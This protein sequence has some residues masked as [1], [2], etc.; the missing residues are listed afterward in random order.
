MQAALTT[1]FD[2]ERNAG[3]LIAAIGLAALV[4]AAVFY[5]PRWGF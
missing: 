1:Y 2:G 5:Q 4:V 3:L